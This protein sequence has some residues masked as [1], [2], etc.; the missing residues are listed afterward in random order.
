MTD[1]FV[2]KVTIY[3][4]I[5]S[6]GVN[7]RSFNRFV[8]DKCMVYNQ[9]TESSDGTISKVVNAQN[10]I[11]KDVEHYKSPLEYAGLPAD[12]KEKFYT[13]Q[14]DDFVVLAEVE[15]VVTTSREF[16]ALQEKYAQVHEGLRRQ[17]RKR[18]FLDLRSRQGRRVQ[19]REGLF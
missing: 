3:N 11:T 5:A 4:D 8:I 17:T 15:D 7:P 10:V 18:N 14:V 1:L 12:E 13:V 2:K 9:A 6:D 19:W 16:Q